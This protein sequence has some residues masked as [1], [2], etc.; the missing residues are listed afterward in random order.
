MGIYY[1]KDVFE[2]STMENLLSIRTML[3]TPA[4]RPERFEKAKDFGADGIVIDLEDSVSLANKDNAR[5][6]VVNYLKNSSPLKNF[7]RCLRINSIKTPAGLK[8]LSALIDNKLLP[9][10]VV[11]PKTE[12]EAEIKIIDTLLKPQ[13]IPYIALIETAMGLHNSAS[14]A[15]CSP[16]VQAICFG[17]GDLAA[18]LGATLTWE[19]MLM[20]RSLIVRSAAM[21]GIAV[22]DVPYLHLNEAD[23]RGIQEETERVKALG[24]TG[25]FAIHPKQVKPILDVF[26]P[27]QEE[28]DRAQRIVDVY[29]KSQGNVCEIDGKM[30]DV[31]LVRSAKRVLSFVK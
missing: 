6:I 7:I 16:N 29:E 15:T 2:E 27:Q 28:I 9:D 24:Y 5:E 20:A 12:Y 26:T 11:I 25:K 14:I 18:D 1:L 23:D 22:F 30:I 19:P 8:D 4:N 10:V 31:P 13:S 3:F 21:A 17:G